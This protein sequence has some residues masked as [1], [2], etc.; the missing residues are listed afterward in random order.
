MDTGRQSRRRFL[1]V[2]LGVAGL[3]LVL[4]CG[5][6]PWQPSQAVRIR[7]IGFLASFPIPLPPTPGSGIRAFHDSLHELGWTEGENFTIEYRSAELRDEQLP[8]LAAE[9]VNL[10]VDVIVASSTPGALAAK[11]ASSTVPI[12]MPNMLDPVGS[13]LV[14]SL[15]RPGTNVTGLSFYGP[16]LSGKRLQLLKEVIPSLLSVAVLWHAN[17]P[18]AAAD[19][20]QT[21]AA[22]AAL[23][24]QIRSE[25]VRS[26]DDFRGAFAAIAEQRPDALV[27]LPDNLTA[28]NSQ[29]IVDFAVAERL[30]GM[31]P[32]GFF[33]T[34]VGLMA[35]GPDVVDSYQRAA[36]YVDKILKG[37]KPADLPVEQPTKLD[38]VINLKTAHALGLAIPKSVLE[39]TTQVIQ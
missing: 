31:Y 27:V 10:G 38:F 18:A 21:Q 5:R 19:F 23:N 37:V 15:A 7:R 30:P 2:S 14:E 9:L 39:S 1:R 34:Q 35:Y 32:Q 16:V 3:S 28:T 8:E 24:L 11:Q 29:L 4:G 20:R 33:A 36:A 12:V 26:P 22:A 17:N 25:E 13:G 6:L